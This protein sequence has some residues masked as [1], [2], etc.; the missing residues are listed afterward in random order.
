M[1]AVDLIRTKRDGGAL[2]REEIRFF[3]EGVTG[4]SIPPYQ[5][6]ALLMAIRIRGMDAGETAA[7]T[8]AMAAS[9]SRLDLAGLP[10]PTVDKHSTGGVGDKTSL[11]IAPLVAAC[12]GIVPMMSGR[13]LGHTGGTL[14]KLEA[15]PGVRTTLDAAGLRA[16]LIRAGCAIFGQTEAIAPA[17]KALY[18][19]RDQTATIDSLPLITA[20]IM[21]KKIAEGVGALV[22]D[23]KAGAG[24][25][26][27]E[28]R[29]ARQLAE[30]LV[31]AGTRAGMHTEAL[32]SSMDAPLGRAVGNALEVVEAVDVLR[33]GGPGDVRELSLA[34]ASRMLVAAGI[35]ADEAKA[36]Q[37]AGRALTSGAALER[38][39]ALLEAQG[40][41]GRCADD[42]R[43]LP[44][45]PSVA[46]LEA[47]RDGYLR[48]LDALSV[49]RAAMALGAGRQRTD[50][51]LDPA[52][53][54]VLLAKPGDRVGAGQPVLE[55]HYRDQ[56][57]LAVAAGIAAAAIDI[58]DEPPALVP[59]IRDRLHA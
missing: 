19:L 5:A 18:A 34:L 4:G 39:R 22:L 31:S 35:A 8:D 21:S 36:R 44:A 14:D 23:V 1:R 6:A 7:L 57:R 38:F 49:G 10:G 2:S 26:M 27:R 42:P 58:S 52:V 15:I 51:E 37:R 46:A 16:C 33:G 53:G 24:A 9:G 47:P 45:A 55:L 25:F 11:V 3:V 29:D 59:L 56:D 54:L 40:G 43:L 17:D 20:S 28:E 12:G 30:S 41:D 48:G 13:G 32:I 50:D